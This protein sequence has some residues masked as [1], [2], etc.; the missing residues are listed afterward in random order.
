MVI[1]LQSNVQCTYETYMQRSLSLL[2]ANMFA[3]NN[4]AASQTGE[5]NESTVIIINLWVYGSWSIVSL[6]YICTECRSQRCWSLHC[7][8]CWKTV[9]KFLQKEQ[10]NVHLSISLLCHGWCLAIHLGRVLSILAQKRVVELHMYGPNVSHQDS[11]TF[12]GALMCSAWKEC[13]A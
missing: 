3:E 1:T 6:L 10:P 7:H 4:T 2:R 5:E 13:L 11:G 9:C 8:L 12:N